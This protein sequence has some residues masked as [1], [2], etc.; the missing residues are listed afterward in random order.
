MQLN[1]KFEADNN[2]EYKIKGIQNSAVYA[3]E[4]AK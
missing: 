3:K 4:S 2:K 1:F